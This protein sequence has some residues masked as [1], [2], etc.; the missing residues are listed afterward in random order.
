MCQLRTKVPPLL[1][2]SPPNSISDTYNIPSISI[3]KDGCV[4][5]GF[6]QLDTIF[7]VFILVFTTLLR[8]AMTVIYQQVIA[9][10]F[11]KLNDDRNIHLGTQNGTLYDVVIL[12]RYRKS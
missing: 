5:H 2:G 7:Y 12:Y 4:G 8:H 10:C 11:P 3:V 9:K 1:E 6:Q